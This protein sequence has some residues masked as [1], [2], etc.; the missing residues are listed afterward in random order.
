MINGCHYC[1]QWYEVSVQVSWV[2]GMTDRLS[3]LIIDEH[4][5]S[6]FGLSSLIARVIPGN[7]VEICHSVEDVMKLTSQKCFERLLIFADFWLRDGTALTVL[8]L[9]EQQERP[10]KMIVLSGD[11]HP[12]LMPKLSAAGVWGFM[13]KAASPEQLMDLINGALMDSAPPFAYVSSPSTDTVGVSK[14]G[15]LK[16]DAGELGLTSRQLDI[17]SY[18]LSGRANKIIAKELKIAEQTVK[19]HV[20]RILAHFN[21]TNRLQLIQHFTNLRMTV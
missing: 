3:I 13:S 6:A 12:Q 10:M 4:W 11:N 1:E 15:V 14:H 19:E 16:M 8:E 21:V 9:L 20:T 18:V 7:T 2:C 5:V 17:L